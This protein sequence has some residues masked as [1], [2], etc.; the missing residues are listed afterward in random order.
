METKTDIL[1]GDSKKILKDLDTNSID[2]IIKSPPYIGRI[3]ISH[4][5]W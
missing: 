4:N 2:L 5:N 3:L 1:L